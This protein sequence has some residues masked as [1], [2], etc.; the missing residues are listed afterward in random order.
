MHR[1]FLFCNIEI[2]GVF[3]CYTFK[4][5][6]PLLME[7][8]LLYLCMNAT[9]IFSAATTAKVLENI[10]VSTIVNY[11]ETLEMSNLIYLSK[12]MNG[13]SPQSQ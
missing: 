5:R 7:K 10:S 9:E 3:L 13:D 2:V 12:T 11:I 8:L 4:L 1:L 6:N